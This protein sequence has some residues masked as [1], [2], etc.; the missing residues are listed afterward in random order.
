MRGGDTEGYCWSVGQPELRQGGPKEPMC[1][2]G[3]TGLAWPEAE[4]LLTGQV[5]CEC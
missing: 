4:I 5:G 1:I 3:V 2:P